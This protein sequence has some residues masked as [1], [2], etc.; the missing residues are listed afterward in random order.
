[1]D[2][3]VSGPPHVKVGVKVS[4]PPH[5]KVG[6]KVSGPPHVK[7]DVKVDHVKVDHRT[8]VSRWQ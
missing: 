2:V 5:V 1:M 8:V 6:V 4:G 7:V 3:K